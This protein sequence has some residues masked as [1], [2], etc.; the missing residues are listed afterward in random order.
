[1]VA[2]IV[3]L[4]PVINSKNNITSNGNSTIFNETEIELKSNCCEPNLACPGSHVWFIK[5]MS[6]CSGVGMNKLTLVDE[7]WS[8]FTLDSLV[9]KPPPQLQGELPFVE[10]VQMCGMHTFLPH[11]WIL[12]R[13]PVNTCSSEQLM[14]FLWSLLSW[15]QRPGAGPKHPERLDTLN[16]RPEVLFTKTRQM[17]PHV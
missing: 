8:L 10:Q 11:D 17:V 2:P 15:N 6:L 4:C 16:Y 9:T 14:R 12:M 5:V 13:H 3:H 7:P 1:M